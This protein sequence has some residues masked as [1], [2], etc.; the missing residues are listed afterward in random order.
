VALAGP[1]LARSGVIEQAKSDALNTTTT[2]VSSI[3]TSSGMFF[4]RAENELINR[5]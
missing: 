2:M 4:A 5:E 1:R 3:R